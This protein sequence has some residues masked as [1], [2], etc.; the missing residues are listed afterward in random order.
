SMTIPISVIGIGHVTAFNS[1]DIKAQVEGVLM[2]VSYTE[3]QLVKMGDTLVTIDPSIYQAQLMDAEGALIEAKAKK[4]FTLNKQQRYSKLVKD[5][6]VSELNYF[7][8]VT[9]DEEADGQV[10]Q[11]EAMVQKNQ[12]TL[13][14][15]YIKAPFTGR[16]SKKLVD[17]G[18]LILNGQQTLVTINQISPI[19]IDFSVPEFELPR[20]MKYYNQKPL[21]VKVQVNGSD[22]TWTTS[23]VVVDNAIDQKTGTIPLRAQYENTE[24][25]LWPGQFTRCELVLYEKPNALMVPGQAVS[26]GR[27]GYYVVTV[28]KNN[29]AKIHWVK[30]GEHYNDLIEILTDEVKPGDQ[31]IIDGQIMVYDGAKVQVTN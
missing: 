27:F 10:I 26:M 23:L 29:T 28:D 25:A 20:I 24:E 13:D 6:F 9:N 5:Q 18:N 8:Y 11:T 22:E 4:A 16:C 15:C 14:Y 17:I 30:T 3:G 31:V 19:Y 12:V 7:E 21:N 2:D 1:A